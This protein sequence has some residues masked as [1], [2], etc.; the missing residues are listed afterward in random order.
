MS[1]QVLTQGGGAGGASA[2]IFVTGLSEADT[3]TAT[4]D[5]KTVKGK[6]NGN[7]HIITIKDYGLWTVTATNGEDTTTQDVLVD[8]A[9]DYEIEMGYKLWLYREGDKCEVITGG[10]EYNKM[11]LWN[12]CNNGTA[13]EGD[14]Y[15]QLKSTP[16]VTDAVCNAS[17]INK[18][19]V[20]P[21]SK[22]FI[23]VPDVY[24]GSTS[25]GSNMSLFTEK[26]LVSGSHIRRVDLKT[27][28]LHEMDVSDL[29]GEFY[30]VVNAYGYRATATI[31]FDNIWLE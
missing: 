16:S 2:S 3:V 9:I 30:I 11:T 1:L 13:T 15:I 25:C 22:I 6:W 8:A 24:N 20:T 31:Q 18:T 14:G 7:G 29:S 4:K 17:P 26:P 10:W 12:G 5:G 28:G 23:N 21:L 27:T 19:D